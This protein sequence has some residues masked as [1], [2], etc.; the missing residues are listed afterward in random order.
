MRNVRRVLPRFLLASLVLMP[1]G[2]CKKE[3]QVPP[4]PP[5]LPGLKAAASDRKP[6]A[7]AQHEMPPDHPAMLRSRAEMEA[8]NP[9]AQPAEAAAAPQAGGGTEGTIRGALKIADALKAKAAP[10][11]TIFLV[12]RMAM[13]GAP[14]PVVAVQR[15][16]VGAWPQPFELTQDNVMLA[17]MSLKGKVVLTAR[18][19]QDGDAMTKQPGDIEGATPAI[20]VPAQSVDLV[21]DKVRTEAA[22]APSPAGMGEAHPGPG[23]GAGM[24]MP[25]GHP[26]MP[27]GHPAMP[28]GHP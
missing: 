14:G 13:D 25:P 21:L 7:M 22:G 26:A 28:A 10:G 8:A 15:Y 6:G 3:R 19:D 23:M 12:A 5:P 4:G 24:G 20:T 2:A 27:P 17:G 18:V 1:F 11:A 16:T 9:G